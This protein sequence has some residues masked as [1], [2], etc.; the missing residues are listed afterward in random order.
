MHALQCGLKFTSFGKTNGALLNLR[1]NFDLS[2]VYHG[3]NPVI[4]SYNIMPNP[5]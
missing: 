3:G 4:I 2:V 1:N 5:Q